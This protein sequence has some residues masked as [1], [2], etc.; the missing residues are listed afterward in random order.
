[1]SIGFFGVFAVA[2]GLTCISATARLMWRKLVFEPLRRWVR[3]KQIIR[4]EIKIAERAA[5]LR[6]LYVRF[7]SER[8]Q[9]NETDGSIDP[10]GGE[11]DMID[12]ENPMRSPDAAK[13]YSRARTSGADSQSVPV[14]LRGCKQTG[15]VSSYNELFRS[16]LVHLQGRSE[17]ENIELYQKGLMRHLRPLVAARKPRTLEEAME[18]AEVVEIAS[19]L[20]PSSQDF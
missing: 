1:M 13:A 6:G 8:D 3:L 17:G 14:Q 7:L 20:A 10:D 2:L 4:I 9:L 15:S 18:L 5:K 19:C 16:C 12:F 11:L